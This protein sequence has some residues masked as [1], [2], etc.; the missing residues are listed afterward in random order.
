MDR[1][2]HTFP[3]L[4]GIKQRCNQNETDAHSTENEVVIDVNEDN[5]YFDTSS[6]QMN[7]NLVNLS[8]GAMT[9]A[10]INNEYIYPKYI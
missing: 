2:E 4:E 5:I 10:M 7:S 1:Y 3:G 6:E 9:N 8:A